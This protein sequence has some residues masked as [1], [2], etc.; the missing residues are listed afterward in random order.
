MYLVRPPARDT[1]WMS[2]SICAERGIDMA[3]RLAKALGAIMV[4]LLAVCVFAIA[5]YAAP[6]D[7]PYT[8]NTDGTVTFDNGSYP[9]ASKVTF[10]LPQGVTFKKDVSSDRYADWIMA[11]FGVAN[12][13]ATV[14]G[15]TD[16]YCWPDKTSFFQLGI[17]DG[18]VISGVSLNPASAG[19]VYFEGDSDGV[20]ALSLTAPATLSVT[21]MK[22]DW[23][24]VDTDKA[25][26]VSVNLYTTEAVRT[27]DATLKVDKYTSGNVITKA[28]SAI[29][30]ALDASDKFSPNELVAFDVNYKDADGA[31]VIGGLTPY[32]A[33]Q[34][35]YVTI[36]LPDGW[37]AKT[38]RVYRF[39]Q[40]SEDDYYASAQ[41]A[42]S[43]D[44]GKA[45]K[46]DVEWCLGRFVLTCESAA[47]A[48][49]PGW[50][51]VGKDWYY[52]DSKGVAYKNKWL[53]YGGWYYFGADGKLV[54]NGWAYDGGNRYYMGSNGRL[55]K[56]T[57]A[58]VDGTWYY[59]G[60]GYKALTNSWVKSGGKYYYMGK[61]G[62]LVLNDWVSYRGKYY[63]MNGNGNPVVNGWVKYNDAWYYMNGSGNPVT[64]AWVK[65]GGKYYYMN[66]SGNPVTNDWVKYGGKYYY[67]NGNGNPVVNGWIEY[68]GTNYHFNKSGVCDRSQKA[69]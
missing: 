42:T 13:S 23:S 33:M 39:F 4:A 47:A 61:N 53:N 22:A 15:G 11:S 60:S 31:Y 8:V 3:K 57:W 2:V 10:S 9:K 12:A 28:K 14:T 6:E 30:A 20:V 5:A 37:D 68:N 63:Y 16:Y 25:T 44:N 64:K 55:A 49:K 24:H 34:H 58:K 26:G 48:H 50:E 21:V 38:T 17:P 27:K 7:E 41:E 45:L 46:L 69:S 67:M 29:L 36:P 59:I 19:E 40:E 43:V 32:A 54:V 35:A 66:G 18:Y 1:L 51:N 52:Y 62:A 65:S 56:N